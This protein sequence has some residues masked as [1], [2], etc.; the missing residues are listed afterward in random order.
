MLPPRPQAS[1]E[2]V[3][4]P[5]QTTVQCYIMGSGRHKGSHASWGAVCPQG[6]CIEPCMFEDG[7][8][9]RTL[10]WIS[11][12]V[13]VTHPCFLFV[14]NNQRQHTC[15]LINYVNVFSSM[16]HPKPLCTRNI[17]G[18]ASLPVLCLSHTPPSTPNS[19]IRNSLKL[20]RPAVC[21]HS[22]PGHGLI[23]LCTHCGAQVTL[24]SWVVNT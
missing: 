24:L 18:T 9:L 22:S 10:R 3:F 23:F 17:N 6:W 13:Y 19:C 12:S 21:T 4:K 5:H 16:F 15:S 1:S 20:D 2:V 7:I 8:N 11:L 14:C